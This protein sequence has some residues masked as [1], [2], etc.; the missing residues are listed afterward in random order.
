MSPQ[1]EEK[2]KSF[3]QYIKGKKTEQSG[4]APLRVNDGLLDS[5]SQTQSNILNVQF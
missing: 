3:W 2:P 1:L 4:V 5:D